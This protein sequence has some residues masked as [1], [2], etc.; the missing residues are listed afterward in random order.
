MRTVGIHTLGCKVNTYES[1]YIINELK[2]N[3]YVI[4]SFDDICDI[5]II[6]TCTVTNNSDSK[7]KK[8]YVSNLFT[9]P[10]ETDDF[11]VSD[12]LK[13]INK[14]INNIDVVI[15]NDKKI[16]TKTA[17]K[18]ETEEQKDQVKI[19]KKEIEKLNCKL[20]SDKLY[21]FSP[22]DGTINFANNFIDL[23]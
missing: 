15:A 8:M 2:K 22:I 18:Y 13:V 6:S 11:K 7:S 1:E 17:R 16:P 19:D 20:I 9:Q 23:W 4:K 5:Y 10:G 21:G 14:Y 12:H 3:G